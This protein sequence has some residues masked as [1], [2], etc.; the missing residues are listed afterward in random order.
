M[1]SAS[2]DDAVKRFRAFCSGLR[3]D[4][5]GSV[6][7]ANWRIV[8][9]FLF[10]NPDCRGSAPDLVGLAAVWEC[11]EVR[12]RQIVG[13]MSGGTMDRFQP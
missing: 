13:A 12:W 5:H 9:A 8:N 1:E 7:V 2:H 4:G 10:L 3:S 11:D 6:S